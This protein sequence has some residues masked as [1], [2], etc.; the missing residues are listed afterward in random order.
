M[1]SATRRSRAEPRL[2]GADTPAT[3]RDSSQSTRGRIAETERK[4][5]LSPEDQSR[6]LGWISPRDR[7]LRSGVGQYAGW[8]QICASC[9]EELS[10]HF[11]FCGFCGSPLAGAALFKETRKTVTVLFCDLKGSTNLGEMLDEESLREVVS[12]YFERMSVVLEDHGGSVERFIG[13]AVMAVFG[14]R[15][16]HEDDALR[17]VRA[18]H[19]MQATLADFNSELARGWGITLTNRTGVNTGDVVAG[20]PVRGQ[21]LVV[22][23]AVNVA[24]RLEQAAGDDE[25]LIGDRTYRLVR[26]AVEVEPAQPLDLKGK[27]EPVPAYRLLSLRRE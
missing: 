18:A 2:A 23:D 11:R 17:A 26:D 9:G 21:Q 8:M 16:A 20:D 24:A 13:D 19:E 4:R 25:V 12:T 14:L 10:D 15:T 1:C 3:V 22:G 5:A 27:S 7:G 6:E